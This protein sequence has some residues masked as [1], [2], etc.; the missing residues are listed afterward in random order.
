MRFRKGCVAQLGQD[1]GQP[2][3]GGRPRVVK[4]EGAKGPA[5]CHLTMQTTSDSLHSPSP[6]LGREGATRL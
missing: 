3:R 6:Q 4:E 5:V 1:L 2:G